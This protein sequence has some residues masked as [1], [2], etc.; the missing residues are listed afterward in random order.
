MFIIPPESI[1]EV[2]RLSEAYDPDTSENNASSVIRGFDIK[3]STYVPITNGMTFSTVST[4]VINN[5]CLDSVSCSTATFDSYNNIVSSNSIS[6]IVFQPTEKELNFSTKINE[7]ELSEE[8]KVE[9][10]VK[11]L[12]SRRGR[13][14]SKKE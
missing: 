6:N 4:D 3:D 5:V 12:T 8:N 13:K 10:A 14:P 2:V 11:K 1:D 7:M 9:N